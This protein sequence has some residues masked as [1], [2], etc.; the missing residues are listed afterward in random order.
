[1]LNLGLQR[2]LGNGAGPAGAEAAPVT[3]LKPLH[4]KIEE[5]TLEKD[6]VRRARADPGLLSAKR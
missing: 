2:W 6:F 1:M 4:A 3:D 5:L